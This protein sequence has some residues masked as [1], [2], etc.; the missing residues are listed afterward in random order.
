MSY[1]GYSECKHCLR[2][3]QGLVILLSCKFGSANLKKLL[4]I[5]SLRIMILSRRII[6]ITS[7]VHQKVFLS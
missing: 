3:L 1:D 4:K 5:K 2:Q 6:I 7:N